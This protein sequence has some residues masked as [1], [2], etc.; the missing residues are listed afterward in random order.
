MGHW[1]S[2][3]AMLGKN[4][5]ISLRGKEKECLLCLRFATEGHTFLHTVSFPVSNAF[6]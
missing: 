4:S 5:G 2:G 1:L 6:S 3:T